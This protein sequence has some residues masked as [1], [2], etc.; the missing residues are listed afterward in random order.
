[1]KRILTNITLAVAAALCLTSH[2]GSLP[3]VKTNLLYD[4]LLNA[5]LGVE[6]KMSRRWSF[7]LSGNYNG[8][9]LSHGRQWKH[10]FVQP[11]ARY[12]LNDNMKGHFFAANL[13]G[14]QFNTTLNGARR[15]GWGAGIS[16]GYG[17]SWHF[18]SHWG[19]EVELTAG[20]VRYRYDKYPCAG[21]GRKIG[22]RNRNYIGP[23]KAAVSLVYYFGA[24]KEKEQPA[25]VII[26]LPVKEPAAEPAPATVPADTLPQ[27]DFILVDAQRGRVLTETLSGVARVH[28]GV[29]RT[30][31][32]RNLG[33]NASELDAIVARLDSIRDGL[34]MQIAMV[35]FTGY[36]SPEGSY[37]NNDR[38]AAA[39][40]ASLREEIGRAA[41]LPDS[42]IAVRHV[43]ED[44]EGLREAVAQS[45]LDDR[46][47][48]LSIIDSDMAADAKEAAMKRRRTSWSRIASEMLPPLR[49]TEYMI[50]YT[51]RYTEQ[52]TRTLDEVNS[53]ITAGDTDRAARLLVDIP[54]SPEAD[55]A[56][57]VVAALRQNYDEA[58]AWFRRAQARGVDAATDALRQL[59]KRDKP[60][61]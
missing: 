61:D 40:T 2:A 7:D 12:W 28:F 6:F 36:A 42:V 18:G 20:Y 8:W 38:L 52:E 4:A 31:I 37:R 35:Q 5:N 30:D 23:T 56:R 55:Y 44:W 34:D 1:M 54:S 25:P 41:S 48:L 58:E 46:D 26:P 10:W 15:Q 9:R 14:G 11:E 59:E 43:A 45:D 27:F 49:R 39:R 17:Y 19:V 22:T 16:A 57:G 13:I 51:H 60:A 24:E 53:A 29:N 33:E 47:A 32:D 50:E 21:C 3:A